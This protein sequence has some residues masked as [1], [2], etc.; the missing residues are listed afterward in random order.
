MEHFAGGRNVALATGG[1][2]E[3]PSSLNDSIRWVFSTSL[4]EQELRGCVADRIHD[5]SEGIRLIVVCRQEKGKGVD[6]VIQSLQLIR[7]QFPKATLDVVGD[8]GALLDLK[9]LTASLGLE[10]C[11]R[12]HGKLDHDKVMSLL[13]QSDLFCYPT[14][15]EGFPK[16]VLE[17]LACGVPVVTTRV[18]V[19]PQLVG[20]RCGALIDET[21]PK[22]VAEAVKDCVRDPQAYQTMSG[23]AKETAYQYSLERW[24]DTIGDILRSA[25]G[26]LKS[27]V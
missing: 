24:R 1:A 15:S 10:D 25:W 18:S 9:R 26:P 3:P 27:D 11:V 4:T 14:G 8:G 19:L 16:A 2:V 20:D 22:A 13:Q 6:V 12:F 17:A 5:F 23:R 21:S 7:A